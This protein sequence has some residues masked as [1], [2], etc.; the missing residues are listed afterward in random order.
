[1]DRH[2]LCLHAALAWCS[3]RC[4]PEYCYLRP[5][6]WPVDDVDLRPI[7]GQE[8]GLLHS[9]V[10]TANDSYGLVAEQGG[11]PITDSTSA[12]ALVPAS[13]HGRECRRWLPSAQSSCSSC[14]LLA[15][16][17][18]AGSRG[19]LVCVPG[20]TDR[21]TLARMP[22]CCQGA[23]V[24]G[25]MVAGNACYQ[26][27]K[28][29][30]IKGGHGTVLWSSLIFL[31]RLSLASP[32]GKCLGYTH[33]KPLSSSLPGKFMRLATA[34][35][36]IITVSAKYSRSED[37]TRKGRLERSTWACHRK[38]VWISLHIMISNM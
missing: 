14:S 24:T 1:M 7:L 17:T 33:Q 30:G 15:R 9:A 12:D 37:L 23:K 27:R 21:Y 29:L 26:A 34:P 3:E 6:H 8:V 28:W 11:S 19:R 16:S 25:H 22:S 31:S 36:E 38:R 5:G 32:W 10:A 13:I 18:C 2:A 20:Q 4:T 35:V